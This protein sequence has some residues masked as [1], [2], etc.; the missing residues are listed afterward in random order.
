TSNP[1]RIR[2]TGQVFSIVNGAD[3]PYSV[4]SKRN[5]ETNI[6]KSK[7]KVCKEVAGVDKLH[8]EFLAKMEETIKAQFLQYEKTFGPC[9]I[10]EYEIQIKG[11]GTQVKTLQDYQDTLVNE[12]KLLRKEMEIYKT[13]LH[14]LEPYNRKKIQ[15]DG[16]PE[17]GNETMSGVLETLSG[18]VGVPSTDFVKDAPKTNVYVNEHLTP[19]N[20]DLLYNAKKLKEQGWQYVWAREGKIF[21]KQ[22]EDGKRIQVTS[23]EQISK[24]LGEN[25]SGWSAE[26]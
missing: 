1:L 14:E 22:K 8:A 9:P 26:S 3:Y 24:L 23:L 19:F 18:V 17:H 13:K 15:I 11:Y 2:M 20:K 6:N 7:A 5:Q 21:A 25:R 16:V 10:D 12:N 4:H